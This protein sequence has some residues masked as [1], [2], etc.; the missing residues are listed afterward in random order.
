[1]EPRRPVRSR[2]RRRP[3]PHRDHRRRPAPDLP[4]GRRARDAARAPPRGAGREGR[5]TT[6]ASTSTTGRSTSRGC[7]PRTSCGRFRSTSTTATSR[8]S[9]RYL[10]DNADLVGADPRPR[11]RAADRRGA[12]TTARSSSRSSRSRTGPSEDLATHRRGRVRG[13]A[14]RGVTG[15]RLPAAVRGRPLHPLH[16]RDDRDAQ[17]RHVD[18]EGLLP[19]DDRP[20]ARA[21]R[22]QARRA[23]PTWWT[24]RSTGTP[25]VSFPIPPLMHGA[26]LWVALMA[27]LRREHAGAHVAA[28]DGSARDLG[29][30]RAR[31]GDGDHD[32]RRRDGPSADRGAR[33]AGRVVRPLRAVRHRLRRGDAL[34]RGQGEDRASGCRT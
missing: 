29:D 19:L 26:A 32:R 6:S 4:R 7:S 18:P 14:G 1:M 27:M 13:G 8:P 24:S 15:T 9:S 17:G 34:A 25:S 20:A 3:R 28:Q 23:R 10:F 30:G 31:E 2:R 22:D 12:R 33:R 21:R 16:R 5:A 11:V